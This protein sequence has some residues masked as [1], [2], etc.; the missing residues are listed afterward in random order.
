MA[1]VVIKAP[2]S[3]IVTLRKLQAEIKSLRSE[4]KKYI[5][6][7]CNRLT[8]AEKRI[9]KLQHEMEETTRKQTEE[10][11][12][13]RNRQKSRELRNTFKK[14]NTRIQEYLNKS[15]HNSMKK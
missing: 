2:G 15:K 13:K 1:Q 5:E 3:I 9:K 14:N 7:L 6:A 8:A 12:L 11:N 4:I 10:N